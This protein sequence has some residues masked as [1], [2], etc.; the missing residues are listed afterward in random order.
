MR[1]LL[2]LLVVCWLAGCATLPPVRPLAPD[3][4]RRATAAYDDFRHRLAHCPQ[5]I[6]ADVRL[7]Y[8]TLWAAG[9]VTGALAARAP[10]DLMFEATNPFGLTEGVLVTNGRRFSYAAIREHTVYQGPVSA[11]KA[12]RYLPSK[13]AAAESF[14]WLAGR[15]RADLDS[16]RPVGGSA[17]GAVW[18]E[19]VAPDGTRRRVLFDDHLHHLNRRLLLDRDGSTILF[20]TSYVYDREPADCPLPRR[21]VMKTPRGA[22][23]E[24]SVDA[25]YPADHVDDARFR[26]RTPAG[27]TEVPYQ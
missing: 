25:Y 24:L 22:T 11:E 18:F 20:D 16:W 13:E 27:F 19:A 10:A 9:T 5:A 1:R 8:S 17:D 14:S 6:D 15:P 23:L 2:L 26:L 4:A 7:S 3:A 12:A 21:L